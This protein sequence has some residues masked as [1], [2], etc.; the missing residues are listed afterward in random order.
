MFL[1]WMS[2]FVFFFLSLHPFFQLPSI[3]QTLLNFRWCC[4]LQTF[5]R[6]SFSDITYF[7]TLHTAVYPWLKWLSDFW[8]RN[9]YTN[10]GFRPRS[11][12]GWFHPPGL[13]QEKVKKNEFLI[14]IKCP[15]FLLSSEKD[16]ENLAMEHVTHIYLSVFYLISLPLGFTTE[17]VFSV[18]LLFHS[19]PEECHCDS[20]NVFSC[21]L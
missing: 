1:F 7:I 3:F 12:A 10:N 5:L 14:S 19:P 13:A 8:T 15:H 17:A 2:N 18:F 20:S 16:N 4:Q 21:S 9:S 11:L 6:Y